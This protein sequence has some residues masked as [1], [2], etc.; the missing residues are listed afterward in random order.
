MGF[1]QTL[2]TIYI[3]IIFVRAMLSWLPPSSNHGVVHQV[4]RVTYLMTEPVLRPVRGLMP[5]VRVGGQGLD[6][7]VFVVI[8]LLIILR[9]VI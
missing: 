3:F 6:L 4:S 7:S 9:A 5:M 8:L 2:I 1:I